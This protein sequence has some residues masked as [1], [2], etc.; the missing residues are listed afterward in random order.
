[1]LD[2][3]FTMSEKAKD[4]IK[5][6]ILELEKTI[7]PSFSNERRLELIE[8]ARAMDY[9][10]V[11]RNFYSQWAKS[12]EVESHSHLI[13]FGLHKALSL[14]L[15]EST[16]LEGAPL[17][18]STQ[19]LQN[20]ANAVFVLCG[21]IGY[22][23][24]LLELYKVGLIEIEET[25][26][27]HYHVYP[28]TKVYGV[29]SFE[30]ENAIWLKGLI[31]KRNQVIANKLKAKSKAIKRIMS[32]RV[33]KWNTHFIQYKTSPE[34]DAYYGLEG[35]MLARLMLGHDNFP[36]DAKFGGLEFNLYC[37]AVTIFVGWA[38]KHL[39]FCFELLKKY[40]EIDP[41]N[42]FTITI[43]LE[44]IVGW[45]SDVL[46]ID[47]AVAKQVI[48]TVT[49]TTENK[50][51][52]CSVPGNLIT[53]VFIEIG[54]DK[55]L[56]PLW[57]SQTEPFMFL[58]RELRR[59]YRSDWDN[60]VNFREKVFRDDIY[61]LFQSERFYKLERNAVIK[62]DG[63]VITDIDALIFD[64]QTGE[65]GIFQLKWQDYI[66]NSMRERESKKGNLLKTGNQ[67]VEKIH[68]WLSS[69]DNEILSQTLGINKNDVKKIK[70]F[71]VFMLGRNSAFFSG[72]WNPDTR[73]TWGMWDQVLRIMHNFS[74]HNNP[75]EYLY[76]EL[77]KDSPLKKPSPEID[78]H[79]VQV[80]NIMISMS[81]KNGG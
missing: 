59:R 40:P 17:F 79:E 53:P 20:W 60:A 74:N 73:A 45:L 72:D 12:K 68:N 7:V 31:S 10:F 14:S 24:H 56:R 35:T 61:M 77:Q 43:S 30:E 11:G 5:Q 19:K 78:L 18:R 75:I 36:P 46:Q 16:K 42:I 62:N 26:P 27:N 67:W 34:I 4:V 63:A 32:K 69:A 80:G 50:H 47:N 15:D 6:Q 51:E 49:L 33:E 23:E 28:A 25:A 58:L 64:H 9:F 21:Q 38:S 1:M 65:V 57:G 8:L 3:Y 76:H 39:A 22:C 44:N 54:R 52:H 55:L 48:E 2:V 29:E 37:A 13:S 81:S 66:G 70:S 41:R 71:R